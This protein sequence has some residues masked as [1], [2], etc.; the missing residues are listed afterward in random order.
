MN[1]P[2]HLKHEIILGSQSPRR[3]QLLRGLGVDFEI[4]VIPT[5]E[6]FDSSQ[7]HH[8]IAMSISAHKGSKFKDLLSVQSNKLV[9]TADTV[10][11]VDN[12][13]LNKPGNENEAR[14]M[15]ERLSASEH[16]VFTGVCITTNEKQEVFFGETKVLFDNLTDEEITYY[17]QAFRPFD[18]AGSYGV[19][20]W[21]GY[22]GIKKIDGCFFNVM[23]LPLNLLYQHLKSY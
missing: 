23:G 10:V 11:S 13:I 19:Q 9:I 2:L 15:L 5:E 7:P 8:E 12:D 4:N 14:M 18:K 22:I 6:D 17:I 21:L 20:E 1:Y 3:Q 16:K